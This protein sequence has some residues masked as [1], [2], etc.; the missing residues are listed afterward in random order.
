MLSKIRDFVKAYQ[1]DVILVAGV[2]LISLLSFALGYI[3]AKQ[4]DKEPI[5]IEMPN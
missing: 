3:A 1:A 2:I 5:S 4:E